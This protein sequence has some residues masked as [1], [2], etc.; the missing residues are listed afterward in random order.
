M[1]I[2]DKI[3]NWMEERERKAD[4]ITEGELRY[5]KQEALTGEEDA[6]VKKGYNRAM[7]KHLK[8]IDFK[9]KAQRDS[10]KSDVDFKKAKVEEVKAKNKARKQVKDKGAK[11]KTSVSTTKDKKEKD[12]FPSP[13]DYFN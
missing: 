4:L 10:I 9:K 1:G 11:P 5:H 3:G 13:E 2:I 8:D 12:F 6:Y 7:K